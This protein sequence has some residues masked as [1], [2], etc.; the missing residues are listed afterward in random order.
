MKWPDLYFDH[1]ATTPPH[2]ELVRMMPEWLNL[3][4]NPSSIHWA[5][6]SVKT[7][8]RQ[9][10]LAISHLV[11]CQP[12]ELIFT[13]GASEGNNS[14]LKG[15]WQN[16]DHRD[17][18]VTSQV[19]HPSVMKTI[20]W[21]EDQGAKVTYI[22]VSRDGQL[23]MDAL[24]KCLT[25]KTLV[26][27]IMAANN[28]IGSVFPVREIAEM[29][30]EVGAYMHTDAVQMLGKLPVD[31]KNWGVDYATF[32]AH[33]VNGLKG[34][35]ITYV[36][37]GALFEPLIHGG[38]QE[39]HRRGGTENVIG[40]LSFGFVA[41]RIVDLHEKGKRMQILRDEF[42]SLVIDHIANVKVN[43]HGSERLPNTSSLVIDGVDGETLLMSLDLKG[44]AVSTGAACS[45][46]NPEPSPTLLA[47]GLT[48]EEA[49]SSLR[50]SFGPFT[51]QREVF[52]LVEVLKEVV[53]RLRRINANLGESHHAEL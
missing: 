27:S 1:N 15:L 46:G 52:E 53:S 44:I 28:E 34:T 3:W 51:Q 31:L 30:H 5:G 33:K 38:A 13:S 2:P 23:D 12:L 14:V 42:E 41:E 11:H 16:R 32:S 6:Q 49:Q 8:I 50:V 37:R 4:G 40:I 48:R 17:H 47:I 21:L 25:H 20:Q 18:I 29:A 35:G 24:K 26:V 45:S 43:G 36:R 10:R 9:A 22:P 39:R 19:E 7:P